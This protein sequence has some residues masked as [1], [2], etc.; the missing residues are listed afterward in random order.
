[1]LT[2][3]ASVRIYVAAHPVDLRKGFYKLASVARTIVDD[4][5]MSGHVFV[6][7][8]R[9]KNRVKCLWWD[10]QGWAVLY[11]KLERGSFRLQTEPRPGQA[12]VELDAGQFGVMLSG[13]DVRGAGTAKWQRLPHQFG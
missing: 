8:N 11:K 5:P 7:L 10:R 6:F 12:H 9:R 2:L 4:D 3:P 13:L 1:M